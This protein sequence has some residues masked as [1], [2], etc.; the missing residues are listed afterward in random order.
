MPRNLR[1]QYPGAICHVMNRGDRREPISADDDDHRRFL[2][3][4]GRV[5]ETWT[6]VSNSQA[7]KRKE[8]WRNV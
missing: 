7:Q 1:L 3:T 8:K 4:L 5:S 6:C 2:A